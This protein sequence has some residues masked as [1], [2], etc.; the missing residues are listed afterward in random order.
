M[1]VFTDKLA[2]L[3]SVFRL[4]LLSSIEIDWWIYGHK[5][6]PCVMH[7]PVPIVKNASYIFQFDLFSFV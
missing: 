5:R 7:K 1:T 4:E 6:K 3:S 2:I